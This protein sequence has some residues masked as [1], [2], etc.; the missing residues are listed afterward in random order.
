MNK[1]ALAKVAAGV[2]PAVFDVKSGGVPRRAM[3]WRGTAWNF[4]KDIP[5]LDSE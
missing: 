1:M 3:P 2:A 4:G 5:R